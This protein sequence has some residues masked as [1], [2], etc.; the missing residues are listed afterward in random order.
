[1]K[2]QLA[3]AIAFLA[4]LLLAACEQFHQAPPRYQLIASQADVYRVDTS[5]GAVSKVEAS[6][7]QSIAEVPLPLTIGSLYRFETGETMKY[8]G[9]GQFGLGVTVSNWK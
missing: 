9:K 5:T 4:A 6:G 2:K 1:M 3:I 8:L 7:V